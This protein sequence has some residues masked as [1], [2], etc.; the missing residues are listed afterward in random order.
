[1]VYLYSLVTEKFTK[2]LSGINYKYLLGEI[3]YSSVNL[4]SI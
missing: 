2:D 4:M 1:V 3:H